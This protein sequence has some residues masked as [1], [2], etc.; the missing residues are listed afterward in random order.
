[1]KPGRFIPL[2]AIISL[3][4][5]FISTPPELSSAARAERLH[6]EA[7]DAPEAMMARIEGVQSPNRQGHDP[8][9][10]KQLMEKYRVPGV[11]VAV[12]KDFAIHWSKGYGVADVGTGAAVTADTMFQAASIS[13]PVAAMAVLRAVQDG[14][15]SLD[16]DINTILKSW[17][18]PTGDFTRDR[19]VTL[20]ALL[21][22]TSGLGDG[23]GFPG[24]HPKD[25]IPTVVQILNG[26]KP[27]NTG[28]VFMER[29]P[30]T[31]IKYSGG[32]TVVVQL[33]LT[34]VL[35]KP[36]PQILRETVLDPIGMTNSAYE[37]PLSPER[38]KQAARAHSGRGQAM[39]AK[40]HVYPELEAAG[41]WT[42]P[43]DLAKLAIEVQ[44]SLWGKSNRVL[45]TATVKEMV[46]P[47][48]VGDFAVGFSVTKD[49]Q[50][51]YFGHG[52]S[53][54]GFRCDLVAHRLKGYGVVIMTNADS[55]G[56]L[57]SEIRA[58]VAAAYNWDS[59]D[60]PVPR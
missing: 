17:T 49:G 57:L 37:Q 46:T 20:R 22:H 43:S 25:P 58:R 59:L 53:N 1:M 18:L 14:K 60:K 44:K 41:L 10:L 8:F 32:G 26:E 45:S 24:Y 39:D 6:T 4:V 11:S 2:V 31:A 15:L 5:G 29:P 13:K 42:T 40:W 16:Q 34:E 9:T 12:I 28:K 47:V 3:C 51:W 33:A 23:F 27:S 30:F 36:F 50:G 56:V 19:P 48:G 55:G 52:G 21:S 7:T 35:G 38:D 54:W